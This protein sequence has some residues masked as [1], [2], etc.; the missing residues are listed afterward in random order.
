M[1]YWTA[2]TVWDLT[3]LSPDQTNYLNGLEANK[4]LSSLAAEY[5]MHPLMVPCWTCL[6]GRVVE[7]FGAA[8]ATQ[9]LRVDNKVAATALARHLKTY[10]AGLPPS[11]IVLMTDSQMKSSWCRSDTLGQHDGRSE[12][13]GGRS[14]PLGLSLT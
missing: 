2:K 3:S 6:L 7:D 9:V 14:E 10:G 13:L 4:K 11:L 1:T 12:P 5:R 8:A